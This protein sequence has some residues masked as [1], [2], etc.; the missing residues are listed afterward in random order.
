MRGAPTDDEVDRL[1]RTYARRAVR[2]TWDTTN[3]GNRAIIRERERQTARL[4]GR[5]GLLPLAGRPVLEVGCSHGTTLASLLQLGARPEDLVG[6][7]LLPDRIATA[8]LRYPAIRWLSTNAEGL[9]FSDASFDLV[10]AFTVF[11]S[12]LDDS[13]AAGVAAEIRRVVR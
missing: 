4:L 5:H 8:R 10:L 2:P 7:D 6:V 12:I 3:R 9:D 11:S 13:M 1:L